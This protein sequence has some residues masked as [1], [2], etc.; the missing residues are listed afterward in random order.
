M[1]KLFI[2]FSNGDFYIGKFH[3]YKDRCHSLD[4]FS[5]DI[6]NVGNAMFF[7][8]SCAWIRH[9][10]SDEVYTTSSIV[11]I[12]SLTGEEFLSYKRGKKLDE[13]L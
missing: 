10:D 2:E 5:Y 13:L 3:L 1:K 4:D 6:E 7:I 9:E 11:K 8:P 12:R